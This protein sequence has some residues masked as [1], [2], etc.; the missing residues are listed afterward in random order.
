MPAVVVI[1]KIKAS[2]EEV[3]NTVGNVRTHPQFA[4]FC[5]E[6]TITTDGPIGVGTRFHQVFKDR[7]ECDSQIMAWEPFQKIVWHN[8]VE[9]NEKPAQI[10]SYYFEQEGD[11][12]HVLHTVDNDVYENQ[13]LHRGGTEE[14]LREMENLKKLIEG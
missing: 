11:V 3:F 2:V 8:V 1:Q 10:I 13:T 12:T 9:G 7:P 4:D 5:H 6:V 14:N